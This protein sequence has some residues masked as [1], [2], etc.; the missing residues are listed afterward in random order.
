MWLKFTEDFARYKA[1]WAGNVPGPDARNALR[2]GCAIHWPRG[3]VETAAEI[4]EIV[5]K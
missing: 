4:G 3:T 5:P 1:G 2:Q